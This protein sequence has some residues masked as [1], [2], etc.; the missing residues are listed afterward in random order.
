MKP[1]KGNAALVFLLVILAV[2]GSVGGYL[3]LQ[4]QNQNKNSLLSWEECTQMTG[5]LIS[6][7]LPSICHTSD[8]RSVT[9]PVSKEDQEKLKPP[10]EKE[11]WITYTSGY[12]YRF[13]YPI[14]LT[15]VKTSPPNSQIIEYI[16]L[17]D[18]SQIKVLSFQVNSESYSGEVSSRPNLT[19][20]SITI[21]GVRGVKIVVDSSSSAKWIIID[22]PLQNHSIT[23]SAAEP[24]QQL[25]ESVVAT[26]KF[27]DTDDLVFSCPNDGVLNCLPGS[28]D[29][30]LCNRDYMA[31]AS[32]NCP[33]FQGLK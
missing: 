2:L 18:V 24:H 14:E 3:Y 7:S 27:T 11:N 1:C 21:D 26:L 22:L 20:S 9:Q 6:T 23:I 29:L 4:K 19:S 12:G 28:P 17:R 8:G 32:K 13:Q 31:W 15:P 25:L 30:Y 10:D 5:S 16:E 33:P